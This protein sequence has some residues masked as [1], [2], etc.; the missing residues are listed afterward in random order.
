MVV[1]EQEAKKKR[2]MIRSGGRFVSNCEGSGCMGWVWT[3]QYPEGHPQRKGTCGYITRI[4][5]NANIVQPRQGKPP[6]I[7]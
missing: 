5:V 1:T 4:N 3:D 6:I 7:G 2:C